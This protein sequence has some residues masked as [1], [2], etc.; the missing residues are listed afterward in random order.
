M[1]WDELRAVVRAGAPTRGVRAS[2]VESIRQSLRVDGI[3]ISEAEVRLAVA[4][5]IRPSV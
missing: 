3:D 1:T 4:H 5:V 2:F